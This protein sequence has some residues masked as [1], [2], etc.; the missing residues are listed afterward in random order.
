VDDYNDFK[1]IL[2][3]IDNKAHLTK[4]GVEEIREIK[5]RMNTKRK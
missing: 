3:L 2:E 1:T 4:K 5:N